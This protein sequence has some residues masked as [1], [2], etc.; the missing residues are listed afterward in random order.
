MIALNSPVWL[1]LLLPLAVFYSLRRPGDPASRC[2]WL[3]M[4]AGV[5]LGMTS[6][7]LQI[8]SR[9]GTVI[10]VADRSQSMPRGSQAAQQQ[11]IGLLGKSMP[12]GDRLGVISVGGKACVE[13]VPQAAEFPGF[14]GD[15]DPCHSNLSEG[16]WTASSLVADGESA[17]I[18]LLSDGQWTG[19]DPAAAA[20]ALAARGIPVDYRL[21]E[22]PAT[23]DTF[24]DRVICPQEVSPGEAFMIAVWIK[25]PAAGPIRYL[26][27]RNGTPVASGTHEV[28]GG[29]SRLVFR[30]QAGV[31]GTLA[32]CIEVE[33]PTV[34]P[35]PENN[36]ARFMTGVRGSLPILH[37]APGPASGLSELLR[38]GGLDLVTVLAGE[39]GLDL[40]SLSG[41]AAVVIENVPAQ[42]LGT[43]GMT[44]LSAWVQHR[45]G[46]LMLTGGKNMFGPG[47]YFKSPLDPLLPV[48]ME[49]RRE[50]RKLRLAIAVA[51]DRSGSMAMTAG[52]GRSK[53]DL[54]NLGTVQVLDLLSDNDEMGVV[55][56]D[57]S[58]HIIVDLDQVNR[59]RAHRRRILSIDSQGGGIFI[60]EALV[61]ASKMLLEAEAG[62]RHIILFADAADSEEPG[63][64]LSLIEKCRQANITV[65]VVGL[66]KETD[67]DAQLLK[68]IARSGEG[69]CF[70][71]DNPHE[72]PQLFAQDTFAV[73]RSTF[74]EEV[75]PVKLTGGALT[76]TGHTFSPPPAIG[77]YNL[78]YLRPTANLVGVTEDTYHAPWVASWEAGNGRVL[79]LTGEADGNYAGPV[80]QWQSLGEFY[81]GLARWT[82]GFQA[83][84]PDGMVLTQS[85]DDGLCRVDL[86]LSPDRDQ[87]PSTGLPRL[88]VLVS[89]PAKDPASISVDMGW[90]NADQLQASCPL[91]G[92]DT[93]LATVL[94]PDGKKALLPPVCL[95][96]SPE[97]CVPRP[98]K[99][100]RVLERIATTTR[101]EECLNMTDIWH[102]LPH[103]RREVNLG[104]WAFALSI[105]AFLIGIFHRRTGWLLRIREESADRT[106]TPDTDRD[107]AV[108]RPHISR[109]RFPL[110]KRST[111]PPSVPAQDHRTPES[112]P[113]DPSRAAPEAEPAEDTSKPTTLSAMRRIRQDRRHGSRH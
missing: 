11:W 57:S 1:I 37:L 77:G 96:Y 36:I 105:I 48:S 33:P 40:V 54:A 86:H 63:A 39:A 104:P 44:D 99:G 61:A 81:T 79:C 5:I 19:T 49:L 31:P 75:T 52:G 26:L 16:L 30:D 8:P 92:Q 103:R 38:S 112:V 2:L 60:Y 46:G 25:S 45:G 62:T 43:S 107:T 98:D 113:D 66:G 15:V 80:A 65:S 89:T 102:K 100:R 34:D 23:G 32:Y 51:L 108:A 17:R 83:D 91:S 9:R 87:N 101:G 70:F 59:V 56:V 24:I 27:T 7:V 6:P 35:V 111:R 47:G 22:R 93:V 88:N 53:M 97:Y 42:N 76:V 67:V 82:A 13:T 106:E 10:V 55:A 41:Y 94:F 74:I 95:P 69:R 28:T 14:S 29:F 58:P 78:C 64:Y 12:N 18:L 73:A 85:V 72:I 3:T 50:H 71:T 4:V 109:F 84:L 110:F 20:T 68:D 90:V 21:T